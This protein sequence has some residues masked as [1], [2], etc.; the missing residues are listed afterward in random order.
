MNEGGCFGL[1]LL[2]MA[3]IAVALILTSFVAV[4][5]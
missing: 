4:G 3:I 5:R 2:C 1:I